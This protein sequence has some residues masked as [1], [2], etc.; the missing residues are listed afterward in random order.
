MTKYILFLLPLL[1]IFSL[2]L[3]SCTQREDNGVK[4]ISEWTIDPWLTPQP[5]KPVSLGVAEVDGE[6]QAFIRNYDHP[7]QFL[8][9]LKRQFGPD[10][11]VQSILLDISGT[12]FMVLLVDRDVASQARSITVYRPDPSFPDQP[13]LSREAKIVR[14]DKH[15]VGIVPIFPT[16]IDGWSHLTRL[17]IAAVDIDKEDVADK[18]FNPPLPLQF[19][20]VT[21]ED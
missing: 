10:V 9:A 20:K 17:V 19:T 15:G 1:L 3:S 6:Y 12:R 11:P 4:L 8:G 5:A 18:D 13:E 16:E 21:I 2:A 7:R 14:L